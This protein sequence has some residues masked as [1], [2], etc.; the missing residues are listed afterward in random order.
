MEYTEMINA[1]LSLE[2]GTVLEIAFKEDAEC[3]PFEE[4]DP[5]KWG[6]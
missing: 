6:F 4:C 3:I 2:D 5:S 1:I